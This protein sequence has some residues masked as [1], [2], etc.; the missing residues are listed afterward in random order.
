MSIAQGRTV[1]AVNLGLRDNG[2][3]AEINTTPLID[4]ML[5]LLVMLII[6]IPMQTHVVKMTMPTGGHSAPAPIHTLAIDFD[7]AI[8]WDGA[9]VRSRAALDADLAAIAHQSEQDEIHFEPN[10]L[11]NYGLVAEVLG[12]AQRLGVKRIGFTGEEK[13]LH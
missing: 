6:T 11:A 8:T 4:V 13:Y 5:V 1:M 12:D 3:I 9:P 2:A 7:G 10:R